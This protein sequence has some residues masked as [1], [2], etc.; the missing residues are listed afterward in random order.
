M[1]FSY[2]WVAL[3]SALGG[4]A[5]FWF[6]SFV[7]SLTG[8]TFPWGTLLINI[9]GSFFIGLFANLTGADGRFSVSPEIR[10]FVM[11]GICGGFTTFSSFSL[12]TLELAQSGELIR[13]SAYVIF[14]VFL[15]LLFVWLGYLLATGV[16]LRSTHF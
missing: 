16:N 10:T 5:R 3:G 11:V 12:Q 9:G 7:A 8:P 4:M 14:S 13:A 1:I 15:C 6:A 2:L